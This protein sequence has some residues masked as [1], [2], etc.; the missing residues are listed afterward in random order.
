MPAASEGLEGVTPMDCSD[1]M[2]APESEQAATSK[3]AA[4]VRQEARRKEIEGRA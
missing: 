3:Q 2:T 1:L 4:M